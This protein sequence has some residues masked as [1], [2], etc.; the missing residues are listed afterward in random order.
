M[1][2]ACTVVINPSAIPQL[3]LIILATGARQLVVHE[4]FDTTF[5][6]DLYSLWFTPITNI[7]TSSLG[8]AEMMIF[9]A[10]PFMC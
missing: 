4:A 6:S 8:G 3:S 7:G 10:P 2:T 1:V 9:L 5:K